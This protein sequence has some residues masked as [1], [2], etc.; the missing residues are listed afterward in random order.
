VKKCVNEGE[1]MRKLVT[2][3][4]RFMFS[5][6]GF[7]RF[8]SAAEWILI[9]LAVTTLPNIFL[10]FLYNGNRTINFLIFG[11]VVVLSIVFA[12]VS[13]IV[14]IILTL[15]VKSRGW[16]LAILIA[17]WIM[18]WMFESIYSLRLI[19]LILTREW[20][21]VVLVLIVIMGTAY[22]RR[23]ANKISRSIPIFRVLAIAI[24]VLF[25]FN[26]VPSIRFAEV[27]FLAAS[28][29]ENGALSRENFNVSIVAPSPNIYWFHVDGMLSFYAVERF[30]NDPQDELRRG[31][32]QR[33]F[34]I[35]Y[36]AVLDAGWTH[37]A[38]PALLSPD[39][40][41]SYLALLLQETSHLLFREPRATA[42][43]TRLIRDGT[44]I[45]HPFTQDFDLELFR[46][47]RQVGYEIT[48]IDTSAG[49]VEVRTSPPTGLFIHRFLLGSD[50][51]FNLLSLTTPLSIFFARDANAQLNSDTTPSETN[52]ASL[53]LHTFFGTSSAFWPRFS[54]EH[55]NRDNPFLYDLYLNAHRSTIAAVLEEIDTILNE[56]ANAVII[57]Q[58]DHG[59]HLP[60]VQNYLRDELHLSDEDMFTLIH[61]TFSAVRIPSRFGGLDAPLDPRNITREL[62]NRFV[63][64]NYTLLP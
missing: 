59:F 48:T 60:H 53:T 41:D 42:V 39:F 5:S 40:Y 54:P 34:V 57:I 16:A 62:V 45:P 37:V 30:F 52:L 21:L 13:I 35:N 47:F 32:G 26:F 19:S 18:F 8:I 20:L 63:G 14:F 49:S 38:A 2:S 10:F 17:F 7:K 58:A 55:P 56:D 3:A 12:I 1:K 11:Q 27:I 43:N 50:D 46:A 24:V 23:F 6:A 33:G 25:L 44:I 64:P 61:S 29:Q 31:L 22:I 15:V 9:L 51:L 4:K 28:E 36:D